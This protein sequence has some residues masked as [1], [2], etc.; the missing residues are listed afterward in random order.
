L[1]SLREHR[2]HFW[3]SPSFVSAYASL[4]YRA[5]G[6]RE[7]AEGLKRLKEL[8]DEG[9]LSQPLL[10][11]VSLEDMVAQ[12]KAGRVRADEIHEAVVYGKTSWLLADAALGQPWYRG[13][14]QRTQPL[15]WVF[16]TPA[17][18]AAFC[19]Y[20]TNGFAVRRGEGDQPATLRRLRGP[21]QRSGVVADVSALIT[22]HELGLL[23]RAADFLGQITVPAAYMSA[24][25]DEHCRLA[26][27]QTSRRGQAEELS[28][29]VTGKRLGVVP[30]ED[31]GLLVLD[32]YAE[33]APAPEIRGLLD[34]VDTLFVLGL[35]TESQRTDLEACANRPRSAPVAQGSSLVAARATLRTLQSLGL[36]DSLLQVF[37]VNVTARELAEARS[38]LEAFRLENTLRESHAALW[39]IVR[40]HPAFSFAPHVTPPSLRRQEPRSSSV[41]VVVAAILLSSQEAVP[42]LS[43]DRLAQQ[44]RLNE[45]PQ[46]CSNAFGTDLVLTGMW[47]DGLLTREE[48]AR[49]LLQLSKW[50]YRFLVFPFELLKGLADEHRE[51][52][53]GW[54]LRT[55]AGYLHDCL[56]DPGLFGGE[57]P[58]NP[59]MSIALKFG[60]SW[61]FELAK[62]TV[63]VW[64]DRSY[65]DRSASELTNWIV[66]DFLC[67]SPRAAVPMDKHPNL[68]DAFASQFFTTVLLQA[69][70]ATSQERLNRCLQQVALALGLDKEA[71]LA[72]AM[73]VLRAI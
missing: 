16:D 2:S 73:R 32:E 21:S 38:E 67:S 48:A 42:L 41:D 8:Q 72:E 17:N 59:P 25:F 53:P 55:V 3:D 44:T 60:M 65:S 18:R 71:Y 4:A 70:E 28:G 49:A 61:V 11:P 46:D 33:D 6:D 56:Q 29:A 68:Q 58:T 5:G 66:S 47:R 12:I 1:E 26:S 62:L 45:P 54:P 30:A 22:L 34:V 64:E 52:P 51:N 20:S 23:S 57:E 43:D 39:Q 27:L 14:K 36:F 7:G 37:D 19:V 69:T 13:W 10:R 9:R 24:V 31:H 40:S 50:R 63:A 15:D 35:A